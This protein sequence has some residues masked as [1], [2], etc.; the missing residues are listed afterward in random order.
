[1]SCCMSIWVNNVSIYR[2]YLLF[3]IIETS[4][5]RDINENEKKM[6]IK[7]KIK[8]LKKVF[9]KRKEKNYF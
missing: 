9:S 8:K 2:G 7:Y 4:D 1:M 5:K 6:F 3:W